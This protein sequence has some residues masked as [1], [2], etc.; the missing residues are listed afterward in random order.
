[1]AKHSKQLTFTI[2]LDAVLEDIGIDDVDAA[3]KE[4]TEHMT[5][6]G[7]AFTRDGNT[8]TFKGTES[9]LVEVLYQDQ[10][11]WGAGFSFSE[12]DALEEIWEQNA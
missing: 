4:Y 9:Q 10:M 2:D 6:K 3:V 7:I 8:L 1:M 12:K 5:G 11:H